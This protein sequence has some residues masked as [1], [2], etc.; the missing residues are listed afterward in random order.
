MNVNVRINIKFGKY[1]LIKLTEMERKQQKERER[2]FQP[3]IR[4][5]GPVVVPTEPREGLL[6]FRT[7]H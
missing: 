2:E 7:V 3:L 6:I 5:D 4:E 1:L